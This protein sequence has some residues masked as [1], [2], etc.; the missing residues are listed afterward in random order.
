MGQT[1]L[2][3]FKQYWLSPRCTFYLLRA[4]RL[5][6]KKQCLSYSVLNSMR[7]ILWGKPFIFC[8]VQE[9]KQPILQVWNI[10]KLPREPEWQL[11][12]QT[13]TTV[14]YLEPASNS[15]FTGSSDNTYIQKLLWS[16]WSRWHIHVLA[17]CCTGKPGIT[18][19]GKLIYRTAWRMAGTRA[20]NTSGP[21][22]H[23]KSNTLLPP[24]TL[25]TKLLSCCSGYLL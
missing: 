15:S 20:A 8:L 5:A 21:G 19:Q 25:P 14:C 24:S 7:W 3:H 6:K 11:Q 23:C 13:P 2:I 10:R 18:K 12:L 9:F 16:S 4:T 1:E 22:K 17:I